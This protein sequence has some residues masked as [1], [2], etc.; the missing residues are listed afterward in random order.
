MSGS[1]DVHH[2][3]TMELA[4][5]IVYG[6]DMSYGRSRVALLSYGTSPRVHFNLNKYSDK[7]SVLNAMYFRPDEGRTNTAGALSMLTDSV[8]RNNNGDRSGVPNV[9]VVVTDGFSN[10][11]KQNTI[12]AAENAKRQGIAIYVVSV[13]D[14]IYRPEISGIAGKTNQPSDKYIFSLKKHHSIASVAD[15]I[16]TELCRGKC[17]AMVC[18]VVTFHKCVDVKSG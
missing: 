6:L 5:Q 8:Y 2:D 7:T 1:T 10:V 16:S 12:R 14:Q 3:R 13:G 9:A 17:V 15:S 11:N 18:V 4:R